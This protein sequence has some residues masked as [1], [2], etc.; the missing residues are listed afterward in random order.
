MET[1]R[2]AWSRRVAQWRRSGLSAREFARRRGLNAG[3]LSHWAWR[4]GREGQ[5]QGQRGRGDAGRRPALIEVIRT[6]ESSEHFEVELGNGRRVRVPFG[7]DAATL[8]RLVAVLD[9]VR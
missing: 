5:E 8:E 7:F 6:D 3:T 9:P 1:R 4:L 2:A